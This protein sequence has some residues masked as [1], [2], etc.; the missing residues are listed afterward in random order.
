MSFIVTNAVDIHV[1]SE[2][3]VLLSSAND[4]RVVMNVWAGASDL[5][6]G[7]RNVKGGTI[8]NRIPAGERLELKLRG[9]VY[10]IR[11]GGNEGLCSFS[12]EIN[13]G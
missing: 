5:W 4:N 9:D 6:F 13:N 1:T 12:E 3:P 7:D 2:R 11:D 8:G 10:V